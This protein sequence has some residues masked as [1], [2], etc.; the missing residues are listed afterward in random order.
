MTT[1]SSHQHRREGRE[2]TF[3]IAGGDVFSTTDKE[4]GWSGE[5]ATTTPYR[6]R[7]VTFGTQRQEYMTSRSS[8]EPH[9]HVGIPSR[10]LIAHAHTAT[11]A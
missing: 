3:S 11:V 1:S 4:Q 5:G 8:A 2:L 7:I 9:I 10:V 6:A